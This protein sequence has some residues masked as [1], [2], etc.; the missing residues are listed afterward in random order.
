MKKTIILITFIIILAGLLSVFAFYLV[1]FNKAN[2]LLISANKSDA[3]N[4]IEE[5][6]FISQDNYEKLRIINR[7]VSDNEY[8]QLKTKKKYDFIDFK[9]I[10]L[11][12]SVSAEVNSLDEIVSP[13]IYTQQMKISFSFI[14]GVWSV[15]NVELIN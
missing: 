4:T 3:I 10:S 9:N 11:I 15:S 5:D 12:C 14:D 7:V 6:S 1:P 8:V 13:D 2:S